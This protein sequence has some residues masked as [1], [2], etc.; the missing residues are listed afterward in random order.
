MDVDVLLDHAASTP[1]RPEARAALQRWLDAANASATHAAGQ[2]ARVAV[3]QAREQVAAGLRCSPHEVVFT[4]GG[5][6]A[7]NLALKGIV[8][9]A[10]ER[11]SGPVHLVTTGV[12]HPA[13]LGPARWLAERG[14]VALTVVAPDPD[15]RV[16]VERVLDA[17][18]ADTCL[19]S[20]MTANNEL[21]AVNAIA[22]LGP[23]LRERG[24]PLH[25]DA[26]QAVATLDVDVTA[27]QVAALSASGHKFGAPQGVGVAVLRRGLPVVPLT[28]GGGQ[29]RGVRSGTFA[30]GLDAA[31]GAAI[32]AAVADRSE[33]RARL[34][35]LGDRLADGLLGLDG[36]RRNGP[37]AAAH[38]LPSHVHVSLDGVD[39][40]ALTLALDRAGIAASS[41]AACGS[42]AA[43]ASPV[44][45]ACGVVGTP[46]R[47]SLGWTS[48]EA[49]VDRALDVFG[50]VVPRL[51]RRQPAAHGA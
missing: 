29:D 15:G 24:V 11:S 39:G 21:G 5:T 8:W 40:A 42:G 51:R 49:E 23:S 47:L 27:W 22:D 32:E 31:F 1:P 34:R 37:S 26:V 3:E 13:V 20:V 43:T 45:E 14:D 41:G 25:T 48:T 9:A 10:R 30:A 33:V 38:R 50:D 44:L 4:S 36:V 35:A 19:V 12:E 2:A 17:V 46:L 28:H 18:R 16:P 6:E 7:D